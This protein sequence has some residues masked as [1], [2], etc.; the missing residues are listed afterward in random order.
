[1]AQ[2]EGRD[3][4]FMWSSC[5]DDVNSDFVWIGTYVLCVCVC[6]WCVC[7]YVCVSVCVY[8]CVTSLIAE[9]VVVR[10][11]FFN[12]YDA[13]AHHMHKCTHVHT[14]IH[15]HTIC[16]AVTRVR[17]EGQVKVTVDVVTKDLWKL[18]Y[19]NGSQEPSSITTHHTTPSATASRPPHDQGAV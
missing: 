1:M 14:H 11:S 8:V 2:G 16:N 4:E 7:V 6:V 10:V 15:M 3:S 19:R 9:A 18:G 5:S 12:V 13:H 17:S